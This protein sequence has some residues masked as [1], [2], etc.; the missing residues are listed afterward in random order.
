MVWTDILRDPPRKHLVVPGFPR[1]LSQTE[2]PRFPHK[3]SLAELV[4]PCHIPSSDD[5]Y[6]EQNSGQAAGN[7]GSSRALVKALL[8]KS[9]CTALHPIRDLAPQGPSPSLTLAHGIELSFSPII[10]SKRL[11]FGGF[12]VARLIQGL[13]P[14]GQQLFQP[15]LGRQHQ[16]ASAQ[17]S[18]RLQIK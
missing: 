1:G 12:G 4:T 6:K 7:E 10:S 9:W 18:E 17:R 15:Y 3:R 14:T 2:D 5:F 11:W 13:F 8:G 16:G